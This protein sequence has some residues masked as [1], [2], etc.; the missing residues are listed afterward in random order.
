MLIVSQE[1][2]HLIDQSSD[3]N[4]LSILSCANRINTLSCLKSAEHGWLGASFSV[5]ELLTT[6]YFGFD[7]VKVMLSKGHAAAAQYACL[8]A[9]AIITE[10][11]V[12]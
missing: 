5:V 3:E 7:D 10:E 12:K 11:Q 1:I 9:K 6:L 4:I 8:F 2:L